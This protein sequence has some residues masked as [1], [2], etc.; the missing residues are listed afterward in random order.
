[1]APSDHQQSWPPLSVPGLQSKLA[2][3]VRPSCA[4]LPLAESAPVQLPPPPPVIPPAL[5][6]AWVAT[7]LSS[8]GPALVPHSLIPV[9]SGLRISAVGAHSVR[10]TA[11]ANW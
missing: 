9:L 7:S 3:G 4:H 2:L 11:C 10:G 1:M 5:L 8:H 6:R